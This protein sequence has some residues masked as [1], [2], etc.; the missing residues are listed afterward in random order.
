MIRC[1][2]VLRWD[3]DGKRICVEKTR[4]NEGKEKE[5]KEEERI[6]RW[7][8]RMRKRFM[9]MITRRKRR[10]RRVRGGVRYDRR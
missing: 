2:A 1:Y 7:S 3:D 8:R 5:G 6:K 10:R 4:R 9:K